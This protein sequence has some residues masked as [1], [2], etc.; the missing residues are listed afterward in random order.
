MG[1]GS[2]LV[3]CR[4]QHGAG[5]SPQHPK[6]ALSKATPLSPTPHRWAPPRQDKKPSQAKPPEPRLDPS[7]PIPAA[8]ANCM[9]RPLADTRGLVCSW[10]T[11]CDSGVCDASTFFF[12]FTGAQ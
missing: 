1:G 3:C 5:C 8:G 10:L 9:P 11:G 7:H 6:D 12:Y 2:S 4:L